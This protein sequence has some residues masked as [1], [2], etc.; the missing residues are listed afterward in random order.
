LYL[1]IQKI[2]DIIRLDMMLLFEELRKGNTMQTSSLSDIIRGKKAIV[3]DTETTG[4]RYDDEVVEIA[5][6]DVN[7]APLFNTFIKPKRPI[8]PEATAIHGITND[9]VRRAP[10][11]RGAYPRYAHL[12]RGS[13]VLVYNAKFDKRIIEQTTRLWGLPDAGA[14]EWVCIMQQH[15]EI[16][17]LH[18]CMKLVDAAKH[19]GV[20]LPNGN[21]HRAMTDT[22]LALLVARKMAGLPINFN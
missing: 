8:P 18:K 22:I 11:W 2:Y 5:I 13:F 4:L 1:Q 17:H 6:S 21:L 12:V 15:K 9:M 14:A 10:T 19:V 7:G 3:L 16:H 20:P